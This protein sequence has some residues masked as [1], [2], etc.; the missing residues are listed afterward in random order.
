MTLYLGIGRKLYRVKAGR[1]L[2]GDIVAKAGV[3]VQT[4]RYY[5][6]RGLIPAPRRSSSGYSEYSEEAVRLVT[7]I[8]RSQELG[9][10][11]RE[12]QEL[13]KLRALRPKRRDAALTA[14]KAKVRDIDE[15]I[16]DLTAMR[17]ALTSLAT[18]CA[19]FS[20]SPMTCPILEALEKR[21]P[22]GPDPPPRSSPK[23]FS[24]G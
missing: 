14:A 3:N 23:V 15:K 21:C 13:L 16:R 12:A 1:L 17:R 6:R 22:P 2:I 7:F 18:K 24:D 10:T 11:L 5:E 20:E 4:L 9:F 8:K 19:C